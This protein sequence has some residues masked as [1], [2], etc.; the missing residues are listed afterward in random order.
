[1]LNKYGY[2]MI[3]IKR[4]SRETVNWACGSGGHTQISYGR[5]TGEVLTNDHVGQSWTQYHDPEIITICHTDRHMT[6]QQIA[7]MIR[8]RMTELEQERSC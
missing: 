6:M 2:K 8:D 4:A 3:G 7:D 5:S 1:M